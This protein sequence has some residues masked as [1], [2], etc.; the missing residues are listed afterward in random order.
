MGE[1]PPPP[2]PVKARVLR[3]VTLLVPEG[4]VEGIRQFARAYAAATISADRYLL[5]VTVPADDHRQPWP[6]SGLTSEHLLPPGLRGSQCCSIS[7]TSRLRRKWHF[8]DHIYPA[9]RI[10]RSET[11]RSVG[12]RAEK[13]GI[14]RYVLSRI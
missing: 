7:D 12:V 14:T 8:R 6:R 3:S 2:N 13:N 10:F 4:G 9:F 11:R 1:R 5:I